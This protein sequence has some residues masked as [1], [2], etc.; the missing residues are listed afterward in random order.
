MLWTVIQALEERADYSQL[1]RNHCKA[2][3]RGFVTLSAEGTDPRDARSNLAEASDVHLANFIRATRRR[4]A[5][6]PTSLC[7]R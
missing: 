5:W 6:T 1:G 7:K 2:T 3:Y 4:V